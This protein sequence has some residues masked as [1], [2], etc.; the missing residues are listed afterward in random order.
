MWRLAGATTSA[1]ASTGTA[2]HKA[3][4]NR[5]AAVALSISK[6]W[7]DARGILAKDGKLVSV[8]AAAL[9]MLPTALAT[10]IEPAQTMAA[11]DSQS[12]AGL[13]LGLVTVII[14]L[15]GQI[16][17]ASVGL[18]KGGT[19]GGAINTGF[20]KFLPIFGAGL[21]FFVPLIL[22]LVALLVASLGGD[23]PAALQ[24]RLAAGQ[25]S[26]EAALFVL[27]W[28]AV[29][30]FF[31][32]RFALATPVGVAETNSSVA[33]L[34]RSW[35]MTRGHFWKIF[36]FAVLIGIVTVV[37]MMVGD[38][39]VRLVSVLLLGPPEPMTLAALLLGLTTGAVQA[40][41]VT[42]Y[43]LMLA[44]IYSQL[45]PRDAGVPNVERA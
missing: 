44:R 14:G 33:M 37:A 27:L 40:L 29:F 30:V 15:I 7:D 42:I 26:G 32:I 28:A 34:K 2:D 18:G 23:D 31:G 1:I 41:F 5:E 3:Y 11:D 20:R 13:A 9:I 22:L 10:L 12:T 6:A 36:S 35:E 4:G 17:I 21:L 24:A 38:L 39:L 19:V 43:M 45:A 25:I 8:V 16:A